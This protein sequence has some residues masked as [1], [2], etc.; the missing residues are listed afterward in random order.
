M[1]GNNIRVNNNFDRNPAKKSDANLET[2]K[3]ENL[4]QPEQTEQTSSSNR[5]IELLDPRSN[6]MPVNF[7]KFENM[8]TL[9][10]LIEKLDQSTNRNLYTALSCNTNETN[11]TF[12]SD[13]V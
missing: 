10:T 7:Y 4:E 13:L 5:L 2:D 12:I 6:E 1:I 11:D 3:I 9:S 8:V